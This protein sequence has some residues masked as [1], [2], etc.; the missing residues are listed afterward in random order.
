MRE[1]KKGVSKSKVIAHTH[2]HT[3]K[4]ERTLA[5]KL[6]YELRAIWTD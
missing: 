2:T 5:N 6:I 4:I 3:L 1:C